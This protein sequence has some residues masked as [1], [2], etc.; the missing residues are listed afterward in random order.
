VTI[1]FR[2]LLEALTAADVRFVVIGGVAL[3]LRGSVRLTVDLDICYARDA[4]NLTRLADALGPHHPTLRGAP[5][6]LPFI[7]DADT[8]RSGLNF[9]LRTDLGDLDVLGEVIGL[10]GY[11]AVA[12]FS[13]PQSI[14]DLS[15]RVLTLEGLER[16][17]RAAGRAKDLIDLEEIA[18]I[19]RQ[20][21][22]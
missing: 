13:T 17:K 12:R 5:P 11:D 3:V 18:E 10:G 15:V 14:G 9:T 4:V 2:A 7:W 6:D 19:R 20:S 1:Q 16:A 8:V 21:G 22:E